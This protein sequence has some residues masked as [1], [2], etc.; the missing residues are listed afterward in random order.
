MTIAKKPPTSVK[1]G[2]PTAGPQPATKPATAPQSTAPADVPLPSVQVDALNPAAVDATLSGLRDLSSYLPNVLGDFNNPTYHI[3]LFQ[4]PDRDVI[5]G[6]FNDKTPASV[7][8]YYDGLDKFEQVTIAETSTTGYNITGLQV[9]SLVGPNFQSVAL[10]TTSLVMNIVEAN[11]VSFLDSLKKSALELRVRDVRKCWYY[12]EVTFKGYRDD[13]PCTNVLEKEEYPNGGR[14]IWQ[15]AITDIETKL[16]VGGGEYKLSMIPYTESALDSETLCVPDMMIAE[17]TTIKEFFD[18]L[19]SQ[20]NV[21]WNLRSAADNYRTY[22]FRFHGVKGRKS[23]TGDQVSNFSLEPPDPDLQY[24]RH[25]DLKAGGAQSGKTTPTGTTTPSA[26]PK[27]QGPTTAPTPSSGSSRRA[28]S[29]E[30]A[31]VVKEIIPSAVITSGRRSAASNARAGGVTNSQHI[32]GTAID[33]R[34]PHNLRPPV[35]MSP[36]ELQR[37]FAERGISVEVFHET[38]E[39]WNAP[40]HYHIQGARGTKAAPASSE[41][42]KTSE[43]DTVGDPNSEPPLISISP[44]SGKPRAQFMRGTSVSEIVTSVFGCCQ[45]SLDLAIDSNK[46]RDF[47]DEKADNGTSPGS[48]NPNGFRESVIFR[49]EPEVRILNYDPLFNKYGKQIIFHIYG[50]VTQRPILSRT[51]VIAANDEAIQKKMLAQFAS[52]GLLKKKYDY[53]FTGL[54]SAIIDLDITFNVLWQAALPRLLR[55]EAFT[56][57]SKYDANAVADY[58]KSQDLVTQFGSIFDD[59][60]QAREEFQVAQESGDAEAAATAAEKATA[61]NESLSAASKELKALRARLTAQLPTFDAKSATSGNREYAE[62]L[63]TESLP[64]LNDFAISMGYVED[65]AKNSIVQGVVGPNNNG[66]TIYGTIMNQLE[67]QMSNEMMALTLKI[68]GDP[69]WIGPGN[70]E[71]EVI[72]SSDQNVEHVADYTVGDNVFVLN[73]SYPLGTDDDGAPKLNKSEMFTGLYRVNKVTHDFT[74]GKFT[75]NIESLRMPLIDLFK[76]LASTETK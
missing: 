1:P 35:E 48:V 5:R 8:E 53:I 63:N 15:V 38:P 37:K 47:P 7:K 50:Y 56:A 54:N 64:A 4:T 19:A 25:H 40:H 16:G 13:L 21:S 70:M 34:C 43:T 36:A 27:G 62:S 42:P 75:Q 24:I 45:E 69:Y 52:Q 41:V 22:A 72:R 14:W 28:S 10:N 65:D 46:N 3:R 74:D 29:E 33:I 55:N 2:A 23:V 6:F 61:A 71:Q 76:A 60:A 57:Q 66:R 73:F 18:D 31:K 12:V 58:K 20:M 68:K 67:G 9:E 26:P 44:D 39:T 32:A 17:G 49:V 11:G 59:R 30:L 51:Q